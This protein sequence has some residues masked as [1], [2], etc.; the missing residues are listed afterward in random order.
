[1]VL[2]AY[3]DLVDGRQELGAADGGGRGA[4]GVRGWGKRCCR[5][6][7]MRYLADLGQEVGGFAFSELAAAVLHIQTLRNRH[8]IP[9]AH[10]SLPIRIRGE[11]AEG[12]T[13]E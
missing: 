8:I 5:L 4:V 11:F 13:A 3:G 12:D 6:I 7:E 9:R 2:L 10:R 1:M